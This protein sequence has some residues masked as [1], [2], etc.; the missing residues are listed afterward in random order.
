MD[1]YAFPRQVPDGDRGQPGLT[2]CDA[3][4]FDIYARAVTNAATLA[5]KSCNPDELSK[6]QLEHLAHASLRAANA[7]LKARENHAR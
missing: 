6:D 4:A 7:F 2:E 1:N 5:D 3:L